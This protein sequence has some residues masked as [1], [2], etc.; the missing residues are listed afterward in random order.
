VFQPGIPKQIFA[1]PANNGWDITADG[2]RF[3]MAVRPNQ[4]A[5]DEPITVVLNWQAELR[6]ETLECSPRRFPSP[7]SSPILTLA[8]NGLGSL[9]SAWTKHARPNMQT[10]EFREMIDVLGTSATKA[11]NWTAG[12]PF[13]LEPSIRTATG[14]GS[15]NLYSLEDVYLMGVANE[16]SH[17]GMAAAAIGKV[18][19]TLQTKFPKGLA[20]VGTLFVARGPEL[21]Y[22]I[23]SRE[24]RFPADVVVQVVIYVK[25]LRERID[26]QVKKATRT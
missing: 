3:L 25:R 18:M 21:S 15:R 24:D 11:K 10:F 7:V 16:L 26:R 8:G 14:Q 19:A 23:E 22:R 9:A 5:T 20:E 13:K 12:R 6:S 1:A 2:E 17:A 4:K